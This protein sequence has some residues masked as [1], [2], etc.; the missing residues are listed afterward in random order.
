MR[1]VPKVF[2]PVYGLAN[3]SLFWV[4]WRVGD[5]GICFVG[6]WPY[7]AF[8]LWAV[9]LMEHLLCGPLAICGICLLGCWPSA[10]FACWPFVGYIITCV[11]CISPW[12]CTFAWCVP[13]SAFWD[14]VVPSEAEFPTQAYEANGFIILGGIAVE[15]LTIS[16]IT[17]K[18]KV[19]EDEKDCCFEVWRNPKL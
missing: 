17:N 15:A 8:A 6:R 19:S 5:L 10:A 2:G 18:R 13:L 14:G 9:G 16:S 11:P 4:C 7:A 3:F 1:P 12:I